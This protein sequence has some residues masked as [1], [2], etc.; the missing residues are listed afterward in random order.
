[1]AKNLKH[2][3]NGFNQ[4]YGRAY[5]WHR[6]ERKFLLFAVCVCFL[7][8]T[9]FVVKAYEYRHFDETKAKLAPQKLRS[10][11]IDLAERQKEQNAQESPRQR[12]IPSRPDQAV[13][14]NQIQQRIQQEGLLYEG[15]VDTALVNKL[16]GT[17]KIE[18]A[19]EDELDD[20]LDGFV[21]AYNAEKLKEF[22][23]SARSKELLNIG[24]TFRVTEL[25]T[26]TERNSNIGFGEKVVID[27]DRI[28]QGFRTKE[29]LEKIN[30]LIRKQESIYTSCMVKL[31][32]K[33]PDISFFFKIQFKIDSI[34]KIR[35]ETI[36]LLEHNIPDSEVLD[37]ILRRSR[38]FRGFPRATQPNAADYIF[39]KKYVF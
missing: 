2:P 19:T 24:P 1:M 34:G 3:K 11:F 27:E 4:E 38:Y 7:I 35:N 10:I 5:I 26:P 31:K 13:I 30:R 17:T 23:L 16:K 29:E 15:E 18:L 21:D 25:N 28:Q 14:L 37:C 36:E 9:Y 32:R 39:R 20:I 8:S 6:E 12:A 22:E 33:E